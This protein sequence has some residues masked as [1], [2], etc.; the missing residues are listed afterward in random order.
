[1]PFLSIVAAVPPLICYSQETGNF[2]PTPAEFGPIV[3][4]SAAGAFVGSLALAY[5]VVCFPAHHLEPVLR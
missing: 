5:G 2:L 1:L 3:L 4:P